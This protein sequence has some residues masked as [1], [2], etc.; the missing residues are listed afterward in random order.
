M[1]P[2]LLAL[3]TMKNSVNIE[4]LTLDMDMFG[5]PSR[6]H[7]VL[8]WD[9]EEATLVDAGYPGMFTQLKKALEDT[10]VQLEKLK[11]IILTH[12]DWDHIGTLPDLLTAR[13]GKVEIYAHTD[14]K[15][16]I[17]GTIPYIKMTPEK[18]AAR[19][20]SLPAGLQSKASALF[21]SIPTVRVH[22]TVSD[23]EILPFHGGL[24][25]IHTPG[26]TPGHICLFVQSH[27]LL[28]AGDQLRIENGVLVGPAEI[29]TPDMPTALKSLA[30]LTGYDIDRV[31]CYHGGLFAPNAAARIAELANYR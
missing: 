7:P 17:E 1:T 30:K 29:Y 28:I 5:T 11:R 13:N 31:Y 27:R 21:A 23:G 20:R 26:H 25:V 19:L 8:I 15:P 16:Y 14:E 10:G 2:E 6:I 12:Q 9:N 18:I 4:L 3:A 24:K 22:R